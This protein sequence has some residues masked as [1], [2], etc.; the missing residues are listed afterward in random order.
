MTDQ[1]PDRDEFDEHRFR[2]L[3]DSVID[4]AI[5]MLDPDGTVLTWNAGAER[6]KGYTRR[7]DHRPAVLGLL[8]ARG[9][10]A[11]AG[12]S[13][14]CEVAAD[15]GPLRGR[16]L[17]GAQG[18]HALLG[19]RRHHRAARPDG[20]LDRLRQGHARPDR[21]RRRR[22]RLRQS[23]ERF[24]LLVESVQDYAIFMLD[25]RA[26]P[27]PG[28]AAPSAIKGYAASEIIG[29]HFSDVLHRP[30]TSSQG[31]PA[32]RAR[33]SRRATAASRARAGACARTARVLG[34]RRAHAGA[35]RRRPAA[36]LRQGDARPERAAPRRRGG[37]GRPADAGIHRHARA[38]AAQSAGADPQ[39]R[40]ADAGAGA[41]P[42]R[43]G[44]RP[45][46]SSTGSSAS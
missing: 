3:V 8:S 23:E 36:R 45:P 26:D 15:D 42:K 32:G 28:T 41:Q 46:T 30:R 38:R 22:R 11:R 13:T 19:E 25:P 29:Q 37:A 18:R 10:R 4:Y 2:L 12:R 31:K 35:R 33:T 16:R 44:C 14:S 34:Q 20:E 6:L 5:F 27:R 40:R 43:R 21:E 24:R 7:G 9:D 1:S 17:A 39:R